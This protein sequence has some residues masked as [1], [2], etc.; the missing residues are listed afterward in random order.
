MNTDGKCLLEPCQAQWNLLCKRVKSTREGILGLQGLPSKTVTSAREQ[1]SA[2]AV[3]ENGPEKSCLVMAAA[4][5][6]TFV[7]R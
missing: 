7:L 6:P 5:A 1:L 2:E 4:I 3:G